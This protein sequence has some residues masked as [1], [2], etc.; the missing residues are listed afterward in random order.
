MLESGLPLRF[1]YHARLLV[2]HQ[3]RRTLAP[4]GS[5]RTRWERLSGFPPTLYHSYPFGCL[6]HAF[7]RDKGRQGPN[8]DQ[9][10]FLGFAEG[11]ISI[12]RLKQQDEV[13]VRFGDCVFF[14]HVFPFKK[15]RDTPRGGLLIGR[16]ASCAS[17]F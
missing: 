6:L 12:L 13:R 15:E 14:T 5:G 3:L 7:S 16:Q 10:V 17:S 1:M 9:A 8:A 2:V 4:D 11:G